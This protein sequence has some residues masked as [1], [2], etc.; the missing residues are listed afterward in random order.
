MEDPAPAAGAAEAGAAV[1]APAAVGAIH[2]VAA[3]DLPAT[4]PATAALAPVL[5]T[6]PS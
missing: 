5:K 1:A 3:E 2:V 6:L 4:H